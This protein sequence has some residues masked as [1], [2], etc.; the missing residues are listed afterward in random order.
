LD[1]END[2][3][4]SPGELEK[5]EEAQEGHQEVA[6]GYPKPQCCQADEGLYQLGP[7]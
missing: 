2:N 5:D 4:F 3:V 1:F 6:A 7:F